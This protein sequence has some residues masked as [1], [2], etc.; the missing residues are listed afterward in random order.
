MGWCQLPKF[1]I[2]IADIIYGYP[3]AQ[4]VFGDEKKLEKDFI[5]VNEAN[6]FV[7]EEKA[8]EIF[9]KD[10]KKYRKILKDTRSSARKKS[11][12]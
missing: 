6:L 4:P 10:P 1:K 9:E 3:N 2:D 8:Q 12:Y 7:A 5:Y 11:R